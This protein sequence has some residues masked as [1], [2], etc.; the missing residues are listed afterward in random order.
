MP[1]RLMTLTE[2]RDLLNISLI[3]WHLAEGAS[4]VAQS[5]KNL[6]AMQE[7]G[8][9]LLGG[10][11]PLKEGIGNPL[12]YS[13]LG[14]P[15]DRGALWATVPW[16]CREWDMTEATEHSKAHLAETPTKPVP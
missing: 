7:T 12:Q 15:M 8:A 1:E 3:L 14:N 5:V 9:R 10:E 13:C 4:L 6:P 2:Q 11:D 16:S